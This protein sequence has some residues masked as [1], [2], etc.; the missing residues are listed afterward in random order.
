[1]A[2][3]LVKIWPKYSETLTAAFVSLVQVLGGEGE[4][5][6]CEIGRMTAN[7]VNDVITDRVYRLGQIEVSPA[8]RGRF[9]EAKE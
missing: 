8:L 5:K 6:N 7:K 9:E 4:R 1:M 3:R 2:V